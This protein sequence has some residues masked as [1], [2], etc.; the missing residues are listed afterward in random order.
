[1]DNNDVARDRA[2]ICCTY[3]GGSCSARASDVARAVWSSAGL[4]GVF[5]VTD[6]RRGVAP[7]VFVSTYNENGSKELMYAKKGSD[8]GFC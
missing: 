1:M 5:L 4:R 2:L 8:N 3:T 6:A 7:D